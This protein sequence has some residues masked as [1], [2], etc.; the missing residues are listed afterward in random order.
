[1]SQATRIARRKLAYARTFL[2]I[3]GK[4]HAD[5]A[6]VLADLKR[7][8]RKST[9]GL[10]FSPKAGLVDIHAT[11]HANGRREI[12]DRIIE[13]LN[14]DGINESTPEEPSDDAADTDDT[15]DPGAQ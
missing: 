7:L 4:L 6:I 12:F 3:D 5:A 9:G 1:L 15:P 14:L 13:H 10:V 8:S 11:M 2:G